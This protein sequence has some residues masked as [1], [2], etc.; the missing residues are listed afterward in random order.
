ME[1]VLAEATDLVHL[2]FDAV[3][4]LFLLLVEHGEFLFKGL[5]AL[6]EV[7]DLACPRLEIPLQLLVLVQ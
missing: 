1:E 2:I 5:V 7:F 4:K 6:V 3:K